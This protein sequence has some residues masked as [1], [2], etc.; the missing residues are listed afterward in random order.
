[1]EKRWKNEWSKAWDP[2]SREDRRRKDASEYPVVTLARGRDDRWWRS[3]GSQWLPCFHE[4]QFKANA[5]EPKNSLTQQDAWQFTNQSGL[6]RY[7]LI[8]CG[9]GGNC[10]FLSLQRAKFA[11][12]CLRSHL[13]ELLDASNFQ[14]FLEEEQLERNRSINQQYDWDC[15]QIKDVAELRAIVLDPSK[16]WGDCTS[17]RW[18]CRWSPW[19]RKYGIGILIFKPDGT[20]YAE[21]FSAF[22]AKESVGKELIMLYNHNNLHWQLIGHYRRRSDIG[23]ARYETVLNRETSVPL[24]LARLLR[25]NFRRVWRRVITE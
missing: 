11:G 19:F 12:L 17:L 10:L 14:I 25:L 21:F 16:Y 13:A 9:G 18:L 6:N 5:K 8:E 7:V 24:S 3:D 22:K 20:L 4:L 15:T 2:A 23:S 1:M